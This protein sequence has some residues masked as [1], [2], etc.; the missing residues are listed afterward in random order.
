MLLISSAHI[1][2]DQ[3]QKTTIMLPRENSESNTVIKDI[4]INLTAPLNIKIKAL[5]C[6]C[7]SIVFNNQD[8]DV[9]YN[10]NGINL[11][12]ITDSNIENI[13][14]KFAIHNVDTQTIIFVNKELTNM[15]IKMSKR[16]S[17]LNYVTLSSMKLSFNI[18]QLVSSNQLIYYD[19]ILHE[20]IANEPNQL[21]SCTLYNIH[22]VESQHV[23]K[24][25]TFGLFAEIED[26]ACIVTL[27]PDEFLNHIPI[28]SGSYTILDNH[29]TIQLTED[30]AM[31][32]GMIF[33]RKDFTSTMVDYED[34]FLELTSLKQ[35]TA[36]SDIEDAE[37]QESI[38]QLDQEGE[39]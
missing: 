7:S 18:L 8:Y 10:P 12:I 3:S 22:Q 33:L 39:D 16:L 6:I 4:N 25:I 19:H 38:D 26:K 23:A 36:Q 28:G 11:Q 15:E 9:Y 34:L 13:L 17:P 24:D 20:L 5:D 31:K 32:S 37:E 30:I 21:L 29:H 27:S 14:F 1:D 35:N 2:Y